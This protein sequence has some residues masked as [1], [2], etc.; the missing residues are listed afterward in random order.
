LM[1]YT[2][3]FR[4]FN[5]NIESQPFKNPDHKFSRFFQFSNSKVK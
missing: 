5:T 4:D 1:D 2:P 3:I